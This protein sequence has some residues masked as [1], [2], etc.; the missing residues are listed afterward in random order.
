VN[1]I[2][3]QFKLPDIFYK[4]LEKEIYRSS[5]WAYSNSVEDFS[6]NIVYSDGVDQTP[7]AE[8]LGEFV[9]S[10]FSRNNFPAFVHV[11]SPEPDINPAY[12]MN[13]TNQFYG[14]SVVLG[15][16][17]GMSKNGRLLL[18]LNLSVFDTFQNFSL[19]DFNIE[20]IVF[21]TAAVIRHE[22]IHA[23][24]YDLR[25]RN[26]S[27]SR[28]LAK[29]KYEEEGVITAPH[30]R[31]RYLCSHLEI[32]AY[33]HEIAERLLN[34]VGL[35]H[36]LNVL[37]FGKDSGVRCLPSQLKEYLT[38]DIPPSVLQN[39]MGKIYFHIIDLSSRKLSSE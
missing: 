24:Q 12:L 15:G 21:D 14:N 26:Q 35:S 9:T 34:S 39:L 23:K 33:S 7:A 17:M 5:F 16:E 13:K 20:N 31:A 28:F 38:A 18:Y 4:P 2:W 1:T 22:L 32:D 36:S 3:D 30:E 25:A 37:R 10:F 11:R 8:V 6:H 29:T 19:E 27:I